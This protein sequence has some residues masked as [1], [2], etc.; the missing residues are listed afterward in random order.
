MLKQTLV[1]YH[2]IKAL[3]LTYILPSEQR[4]FLKIRLNP[5]QGIS[6]SSPLLSLVTS[7][8]EISHQPVHTYTT[9]ICQRG[10]QNR[11]TG[12]GRKIQHYMRRGRRKKKLTPRLCS[13]WEYSVR[14]EKNTSAQKH[15]YHNTW[16]CNRGKHPALASSHPVRCHLLRHRSQT[17]STAWRYKAVRGS[18]SGKGSNV[19]NRGGSKRVPL[20]RSSQGSLPWPRPAG[21][22]EP[23]KIRLNCCVFGANSCIPSQLFSLSIL[24][25]LVSESI[26]FHLQSCELHCDRIHIPVNSL[27]LNADRSSHS[28]N[29]NGQPCETLDSCSRLL[30]FSITQGKA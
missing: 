21:T 18:W 8:S 12:N 14:T 2:K 1:E 22:G 5:I 10:R 3:R 30:N 27:S 16:L 4:N 15:I 28:F 24:S 25:I 17:C 9:Y 20:Q 23:E 26:N 29:Q 6:S 11:K 13:I 7:T 19:C